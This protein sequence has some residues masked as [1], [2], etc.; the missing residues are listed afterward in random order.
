MNKKI[1]VLKNYSFNPLES[2]GFRNRAI[3]QM[4][5]LTEDKN[6]KRLGSKNEGGI[7]NE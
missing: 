1:K 3:Q 4:R 6:I 7:K 5:L 2:D